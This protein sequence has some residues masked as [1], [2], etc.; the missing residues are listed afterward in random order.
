[1]EIGAIL[2]ISNEMPVVIGWQ[3]DQSGHAVGELVA[4]TLKNVAAT[5]HLAGYRNLWHQ[6]RLDVASE[7]LRKVLQ[8]NRSIVEF[9][10]RGWAKP[11]RL[12]YRPRGP[13]TLSGARRD[14]THNTAE[15]IT[16]SQNALSSSVF[17]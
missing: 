3:T 10:R 9:Y 14:P 13:T 7:I 5:V 6:P 17:T 16:R 8:R 15:A 2:N 4:F 12:A 11:R 1:M